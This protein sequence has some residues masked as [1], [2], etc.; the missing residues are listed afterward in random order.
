[1][2]R[3]PLRPLATLCAFGLALLL[4]ACDDSDAAPDALNV[5]DFGAVGD[6]VALDHEA[7]QA[8]IDAAHAA[9]GGIVHVPAG[10]YHSGTIE[11]FSGVTLDLAKGAVIK[12]TTDLAQYRRGHWQA[13]LMAKDQV[14][15]GVTGEGTLDGNSQELR[16]VFEEIKA[17]GDGLRFFPGVEPGEKL[18]LIGPTGVPTIIDPHQLAAEGKLMEYLYGPFTRPYEFV[19]PQVIEFWR[20][21]D[22]VVRGITL[23]NAACWVQTYRDCED[24]LIEGIKVR[25]NDYWNNDGIDLV[26]SRRVIVRDSDIDSA[27]D[28]LCLKSDPRGE[29]CADITVE[30]VKLRSHASAIKFGTAS[31]HGFRR[32]HIS[33]VEITGAYRSV[34]A[35]QSVDGG[36]I[37]DVT[38]ERVKARDVG[39]AFFFR[40]GHRTRSKEPGIIR[41]IVL[42]DMDIHVR[43][44]RP[45]EHMDVD[46][47][48]NQIPSSI[49]G[50][51]GHPVQN[52]L[53]ENI[54]VDFPGGGD[55][56]KVE[57]PLDELD[58][59]P[60]FSHHYPE[61]SM[62]GELPAWGAYIRHAE[63]ITLRNVKFVLQKPDF[64]PAIV[65]DQAPN[66][67]LEALE[68]GPDGGEPIV[69]FKDS[70]GAR[71]VEP[72]LPDGTA[73][74]LR[75][76]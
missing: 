16:K 47:P 52:I 58:S 62:W 5:R 71:L 72:S 63:D 27:D 49:V 45:G 73:E 31:H 36:L 4:T 12:G 42:R 17:S 74:P 60:D 44:E 75:E 10:T 30:R 34:V 38:V 1:M 59:V 61:F 21:R 3:S 20:C 43:P 37:E 28:A 7:I 13:L 14:G 76:L 70:P 57:I 19:R 39:N 23:A 6:G 33:D 65:A 2:K 69:L 9:G 24:I 29:G 48:H 50:M 68:I 22:I 54:T 15:I 26:D 32:I 66:L 51:P 11:L 67:L 40:I 55:R 25:S 56:A 41:N 64:R 18:D 35:I 53:L 8:A 46:T